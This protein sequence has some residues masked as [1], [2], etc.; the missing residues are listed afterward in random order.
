VPNGVHVAVRL[1]PRAKFDRL[2]GLVPTA[3]GGCTVKA[4][5]A[6]PAED[7]RANEALLRLLAHA[8]QLPRRD[9]SIVAGLAS[10]NKTV[11]VAGDPHRLSAKL[12]GAILGLPGPPDS[13]G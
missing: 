8:W 6:A 12:A 2:I 7:G 4:S 10:R 11:R 1:W 3:G 13:S 9:L 5:V